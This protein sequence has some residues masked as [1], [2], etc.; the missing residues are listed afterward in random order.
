[1]FAIDPPS[2]APPANCADLQK[3][4]LVKSTKLRTGSSQENGTKRYYFLFMMCKFC[5]AI[6]KSRFIIFLPA[7]C[8]FRIRISIARHAT[9]PNFCYRERPVI[10]VLNARPMNEVGFRDVQS[11]RSRESNQQTTDS[12]PSGMSMVSKL[13]FKKI[14][15]VTELTKLRKTVLLVQVFDY[16]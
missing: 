12:L 16:I 10:T 1:M 15:I 3:P 14:L 11:I 8:Y 4:D 7:V 5:T 9:F 13:G 2:A 6:H